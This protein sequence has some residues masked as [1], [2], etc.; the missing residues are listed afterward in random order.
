MKK[1]KH[2]P[3]QIVAKLR[4]A[5]A[6][7]AQGKTVEEVAKALGIATV[8]YF[9]WR[10]LYGNSGPSEVKRLKKLEKENQRLKKLVADLSLDNLMLKEINE[11]KV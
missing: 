3:Q 9:R 1:K 10:K 5:D 8:T 2:S 11:G 6:L 4:E 7:T